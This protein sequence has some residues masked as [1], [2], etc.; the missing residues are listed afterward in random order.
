[1]FVALSFT[2]GKTIIS[3]WLQ[4]ICEDPIPTAFSDRPYY[5]IAEFSIQKSK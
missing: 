1:M 5:L 3:L 2:T 4:S